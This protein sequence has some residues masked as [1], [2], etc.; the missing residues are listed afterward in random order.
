MLRTGF[1]ISISLHAGV[2]VAG[3]YFLGGYSKK[4]SADPVVYQVEIIDESLLNVSEPFIRGD[5]IAKENLPPKKIDTEEEKRSKVK[6]DKIGKITK[7]IVIKPD[8]LLSQHLENETS[9]KESLKDEF[10]LSLSGNSNILHQGAPLSTNIMPKYPDSARKRSQEGLVLLDVEIDQKGGVKSIEL[11]K[12]SD[13][14]SLD[15][16]AIEAVKSWRFKPAVANGTNIESKI[17]IPI[18][19]KLK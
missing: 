19:F 2:L 5:H 8:S 16:A 9:N 3:G 12:S 18:R 17:N 15:K 6:K 14:S 4:P 13:V 10:A 7:K 11:S 1:I